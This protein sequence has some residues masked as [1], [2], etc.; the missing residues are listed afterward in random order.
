MF[1]SYIKIFF[2]YTANTDIYPNVLAMGFPADK[3]EGFYR[4]NI[5]DVVK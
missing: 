5:D 1:I 3:V 2:N 4:N